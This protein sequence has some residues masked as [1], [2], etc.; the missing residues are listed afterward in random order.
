MPSSSPPRSDKPGS[1]PPVP[2]G[3]AVPP[4]P[5]GPSAPWAEVLLSF[6]QQSP[7][8]HIRELIRRLKIPTGTL[9]YHLY[10]LSQRQ[11]LETREVAGH[12]CVFPLRPVGE[13]LPISEDQKLLLALLRQRVPRALLL[14]LLD[15]GPTTPQDL[16]SSVGISPSLLSYYVERLEKLGLVER[17]GERPGQRVA[18]LRSPQQVRD[19]LLTYPPLQERVQDRW[20]GL[21]EELR[22]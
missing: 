13:R 16:A 10:R 7:G 5:A 1:P 12:R 21:W 3:E 14:H 9:D 20:L 18:A 19:V 2:S 11:L 22:L 6:V 8:V 4:K 15:R 17:R